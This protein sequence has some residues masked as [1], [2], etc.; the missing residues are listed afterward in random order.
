MASEDRESYGVYVPDSSEF[1]QARE[2]WRAELGEDEPLRRRARQIQ[3]DAERH[4]FSHSWEWAGVPIVRLPDDVMTLQELVWSYR[5]QRI[6]ET[7]VARG[8]SLLM[9]AGLMAMTGE[10]PAVLG[11]DIQVFAHTW[12]ALDSHPLSTG[13]EVLEADS[14]SQIARDRV[15]G[16]LAG[17]ERA[18]L[19]LDSNHTHEHVLAELRS[20]APLMPVGGLVL[21]ADTLIEELPRGHFADRPWDVGNNPLTALHAFVQEDDR[22][23]PATEW[24]RRGLL[25]E[26][27][28]GAL[29]RTR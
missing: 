7:G 24:G 22:F 9:D 10:Q 28:D 2:R 17:A 11:I 20:L 25:T 16:F 12:A 15:Q 19:V 29:R 13:V 4:R 14:A 1:G 21:V 18:V 3:L 27:R 8:G 26:F 6:V 23:Q 5:P